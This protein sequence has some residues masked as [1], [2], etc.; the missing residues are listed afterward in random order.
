MA[1]V[2]VLDVMFVA[3]AWNPDALSAACP[4]TVRL[5]VPEVATSDGELHVG[6][7]DGGPDR[8]GHP[9]EA[10]A[11]GLDRRPVHHQLEVVPVSDTLP[12]RSSASSEPVATGMSSTVVTEG[13]TV[14]VTWSVACRAP[15]LAV[16][17]STKVPAFANVT[18]VVSAAGFAKVTL[19]GPLTLDQATVTA[20]GGFGSPSSVAVPVSDAVPG[21][22]TA[23]SGP[24]FTVGAVF[25]GVTVTVT[26]SAACS[27]PSSPVNRS[28]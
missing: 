18:V 3:T 5:P 28:T 6:P 27:A 23:R 1:V 4:A 22:V 21:R 20:P 24:A 13:A 25:A 14:T 2:G 19:P 16:R 26:S 11:D 9:G 17:R 12:G 7:C 10:Q 15:S 8:H